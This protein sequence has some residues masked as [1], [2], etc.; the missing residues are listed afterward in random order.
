MIE[1]AKDQLDSTDRR[2]AE[3]KLLQEHDLAHWKAQLQ[4]LKAFSPRPDGGA[5]A[6]IPDLKLMYRQLSKQARLAFW[7]QRW[8]DKEV[9]FNMYH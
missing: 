6:E 3:K 1:I 9:A 8:Q 2:T 7:S 4:E 5:E